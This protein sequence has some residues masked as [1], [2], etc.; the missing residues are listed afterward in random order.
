MKVTKENVEQV[1]NRF[2]EGETSNEEEAALYGFFQEEAI[3][4]KLKVYRP[5]F[6]Y[7]AG[8]LKEEDLPTHEEVVREPSVKVVPITGVPRQ[9]SIYHCWRRV[10]L[11]LAAGIAA[12]FIGVGGF[13]HYEQEQH[14]Y[15]S[16]SG[17]YVIDHGK[18]L[19][20]IHAIMPKL[21]MVE[22]HADEATSRHQAEQITKNVLNEIADPAVRAAAAEALK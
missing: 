10:I 9:I 13:I 19:S 11:P 6:T 7:F 18:R 4:E 2:M 5:M 12:C 1:I 15:D 16:Y 21:R 17:S 8:G 20:D 22:A 3:P 14:L